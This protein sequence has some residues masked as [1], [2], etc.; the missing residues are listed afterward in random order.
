MRI[1]PI[2]RLF[3]LSTFIEGYY[4]IQSQQ[5]SAHQPKQRYIQPTYSCLGACQEEHTQSLL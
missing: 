2:E 4:D 1:K 3:N 5:P